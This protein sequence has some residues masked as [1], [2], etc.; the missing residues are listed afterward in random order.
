MD[1][2]ERFV[3]VLD[4]E[5]PDRT[6]IFDSIDNDEILRQVGGNGPPR[7]VVP[8]AFSRLGIDATFQGFWGGSRVRGGFVGG[9]ES[10]GYEYL[11]E[12]TWKTLTYDNLVF[13]KPFTMKWTA[14]YP[15]IWVADRPFKTL[16]ELQDMKIDL[17]MSEDGQ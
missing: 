14:K 8:K 11:L 15:T 5:E 2:Y 9:G 4:F 16:E 7:E 3:R 13:E 17:I 12:M 10:W 1:A 6:P